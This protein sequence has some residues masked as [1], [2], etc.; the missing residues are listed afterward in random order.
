MYGFHWTFWFPWGS[1]DES[2]EILFYFN[3]PRW[4]GFLKRSFEYGSCEELIRFV[5][6]V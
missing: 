2:A 4:D 3:E 1:L 6:E 5:K